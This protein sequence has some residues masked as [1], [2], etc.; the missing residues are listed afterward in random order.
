MNYNDFPTHEKRN[1]AD[2]VFSRSV[3][4]GKRM[5]Y[6]DVKRDRRG[7]LYISITESKRIKDQGDSLHPQFEKHKI[8]LYREDLEKFD[9][10]FAEVAEYTR[11]NAPQIEYPHSSNDSSNY[12]SEQEPT[13]NTDYNF[14]VEF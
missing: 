2:I 6:L 13:S 14:N 1:D 3:K 11:E 7:E 8:F 4:A 9:H 5:Y 10:A 12:N